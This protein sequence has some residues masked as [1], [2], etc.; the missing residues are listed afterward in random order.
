MEGSL[1]IVF[2]NSINNYLNDIGFVAVSKERLK[3]SNL[4][5]VFT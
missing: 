4:F 2:I 1:R 5:F 3:V